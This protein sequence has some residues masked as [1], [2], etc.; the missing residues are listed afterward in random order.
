VANIRPS[1]P[2]STLLL[3]HF[4]SLEWDLEQA[5]LFHHARPL[6]PV[7]HGLVRR[8][9]LTEL[10]PAP[11]GAALPAE[12]DPWRDALYSE[13]ASQWLAART[14]FRPLFLAVGPQLDRMPSATQGPAQP[15]PA[16]ARQPTFSPGR[17]LRSTTLG[18]GCHRGRNRASRRSRSSPTPGTIGIE[19]CARGS[20]AARR[21]LS[22]RR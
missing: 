9:R 13:T 15:S 16:P 11:H 22:E 14:G 5:P 21:R 7:V 1:R 19:R 10:L 17:R 18:R 3:L 20:A 4:R 8:A 2:A 12:D 6:A